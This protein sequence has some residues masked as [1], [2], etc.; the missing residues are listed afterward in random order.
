MNS[1]E[2]KSGSLRL[3]FRANLMAKRLLSLALLLAIFP[4]LSFMPASASQPPNLI[5][6]DSSK[7][8]NLAIIDGRGKTVILPG[9]P[10]RIVITGRASFMVLDA[11]Y[12]FPDIRAK[13]VGK[14]KDGQGMEAFLSAIDPDY[15]KKTSLEREPGPEQI[16]ACRPDVVLMKKASAETLGPALE[17]LGIPVVC[18]DFET[19][20]QYERDLA[21]L[22]RLLG[23]EARAK[24][25]GDL[26][27][28]R[29]KRV[30]NALSGLDA[31]K[32]PRVLMLYYDAQNGSVAFNVP[33]IAWMQTLLVKMA[34]GQPLWEDSHPGQGWTKTGFEQIA[35]WDADQIF[36]V[37]Y[38]ARADKVVADLL[39]DEHWQALRAVK[40]GN[41]HAFPGDLLSWD[42]PD[43]RWVMGLTWLAR[44]MHPELFAGLDMQAE[45]SS[46][47]K[48]FYGVD[49]NTID[50]IIRPALYGNL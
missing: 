27:D 47:F 44:K 49:E 36:I 23:Q 10:Q 41:L 33:P 29:L 1:Q 7:A 12:L 50:K 30:A 39:A 4:M 31:A 21:I 34:G 16:A 2:P 14:G 6:A 8:G 35:A 18:V 37:S 38:F 43:P 20:E 42:Q 3:L 26:I 45:V 15:S 25:L 46:F 40:N 28:S 48:D 13:I 9:L 22:G 17:I 11:V 32:K 24:T 5:N 19:P